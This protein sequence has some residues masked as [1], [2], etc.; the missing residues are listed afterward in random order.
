[1]NKTIAIYGVQV[2]VGVVAVATGY[3]KLTGMGLMVEQFATLGLGRG[4]LMVAGTAEILAGLCLL[5]P[6]GGIVGAVLLT[7]VMVGAMGVTIG[8]VASAVAQGH[9]AQASQFTISIGNAGAC[10]TGRPI[11]IQR[12]SEWDV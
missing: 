9:S 1:M 12:K 4:F 10:D 5:M 6:R 2:L 11:T 7:S 3:A 8:H